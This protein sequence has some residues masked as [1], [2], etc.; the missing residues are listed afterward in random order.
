MAFDRAQI[1]AFHQALDKA[2]PSQR[3]PIWTM[4]NREA[5][6]AQQRQAAQPLKKGAAE[7]SLRQMGKRP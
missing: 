6:E 1:D 4:E 2:Q 3:R 7:L 5:E